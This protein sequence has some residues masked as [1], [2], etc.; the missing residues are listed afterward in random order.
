MTG[1]EFKKLR[2]RLN[3]T[4]KQV[5]ELLGYGLR[6]IKYWESGKY[7][8]DKSAGM[9]LVLLSECGEELRERV[10]KSYSHEYDFN[11]GG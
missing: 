9:V 11:R 3:L 1:E 4:Q 5:A 8:V 6:M 7:D 10:L 2:K